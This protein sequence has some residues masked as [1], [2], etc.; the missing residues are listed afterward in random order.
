MFSLYLCSPPLCL[1]YLYGALT[2][3]LQYRIS[4]QLRR[5]W[6]LG[7][8]WRSFIKLMVEMEGL[9]VYLGGSVRAN[10]L[11]LECFRQCFSAKN[12]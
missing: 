10:S 3:L 11:C 4:M 5:R 6:W 1:A 7:G 2:L 9:G 8:V 12:C